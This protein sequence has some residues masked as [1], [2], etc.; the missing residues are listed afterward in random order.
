MSDIKNFKTKTILLLNLFLLQGL[1]VT[2]N[3]LITWGHITGHIDISSAIHVLLVV[4]SVFS[5]ICT[6]IFAREIIRLAEKERECE[7]NAL[8]LE[9]S[10]YMVEVLR[11]Y[12]HDFL[13]HIQVVNGL[14]QLGKLDSLATYVGEI[15]EEIESQTRL[16]KLAQPELIAFLIKKIS[17][18]NQQ[19]IKFDI[20][21]DTDLKDIDMPHNEIVRV[22]GNIV[23]NAFYAVN[24]GS[25]PEKVVTLKL[26]ESKEEYVISVANNGPEIPEDLRKQI[27][28]RGF[29]TKG[30]KGSGLGL[31]ITQQ[32]IGKNGGNICLREEAKTCFEIKLPRLLKNTA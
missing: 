27:F 24:E 6:I 32:L 22:I 18:A 12:R 4:A 28:A 14:A 31:F 19:G 1:M 30:E 5:A 7:L 3:L 9:D 29:T 10:K 23:D 25:L 13:N 2:F 20:K 8:R 16:N 26:E 11:A 17:T 15:T 21:I